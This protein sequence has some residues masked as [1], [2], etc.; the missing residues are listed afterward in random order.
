M[1]SFVPWIHS[2]R[3]RKMLVCF[4]LAMSVV[5]LY[6]QV[7]QHVLPSLCRKIGLT[8]AS[9]QYPQQPEGDQ[10]Q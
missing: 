6:T 2:P 4:E 8:C 1:Y 5:S 9:D 10:Y 3:T 7:N